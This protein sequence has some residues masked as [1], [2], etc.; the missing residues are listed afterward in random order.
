LFGNLYVT[1][2]L[3]SEATVM[4]SHH[5]NIAC[6]AKMA[7]SDYISSI[8][9]N[10]NYIN[11]LVRDPGY[12]EA[13]WPSKSYKQ[14]HFLVVGLKIQRFSLLSSKPETRH[15]PVNSAL[16]KELKIVHL[17]PKSKRRRLGNPGSLGGRYQSQTPTWHP[18]NK[19][20]YI[21]QPQ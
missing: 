18:Q 4:Y 19:A 10:P 15:Y 5:W 12:K 17:A 11:G 21:Q 2:L 13:A 7:S 14:Q 8:T 1:L 9:R 16:E 3:K 20:T 6:V